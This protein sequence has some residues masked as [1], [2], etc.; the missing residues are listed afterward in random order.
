M[1]EKKEPV[2]AFGEASANEGWMLMPY[3]GI[4]TCWIQL[5]IQQ[6]SKPA[7][8]G[9][10]VTL[11]LGPLGSDGAVVRHSSIKL[12]GKLSTELGLSWL[13]HSVPLGEMAAK[14][15]LGLVACHFKVWSESWIGRRWIGQ[16]SPVAVPSPRQVLQ[17]GHFSFGVQVRRGMEAEGAGSSGMPVLDMSQG[18][19]SPHAVK[20]GC[21]IASL[22]AQLVESVIPQ[23]GSAHCSLSYAND[24][25]KAVLEAI[26]SSQYSVAIAL[27]QELRAAAGKRQ[28][29][30]ADTN[31]SRKTALR[32]CVDN[33]KKDR[34]R[35]LALEGS[36][37]TALLGSQKPYWWVFHVKTV[38]HCSGWICG[39]VQI[40]IPH[41]RQN[42]KSLKLRPF[43]QLG[44]SLQ[45]SW[46]DCRWTNPEEHAGRLEK[47]GDGS[48]RMMVEDGAGTELKLRFIEAGEAIALGSGSFQNP[49]GV[50]MLA[51][52]G[53]VAG[54]SA[55]GI[56]D[57]VTCTRL[58]VE[59]TACGPR[60]TA[61]L[62]LDLGA[63]ARTLARDG[64]SPF[65]AAI[66]YGDPCN[67][68][69]GL[70]EELRQRLSRR[71]PDAWDELLKLPL[72]KG[73]MDV[74]AFALSRGVPIPAGAARDLLDHCFKADLPA[75]AAEVLNELDCRDY[76][77][78][79]LERVD[80]NRAWLSCA[81]KILEQGLRGP[82]PQ[83]LEAETLSYAVEQISRGRSQ[84]RRILQFVPGYIKNSAA[85]YPLTCVLPSRKGGADC[86]ICFEPLSEARPVAF[87]NA[88]GCAV[89]PHFVCQSCSHGLAR[90]EQNQIKCPECRREAK[91][92]GTV[93]PLETDPSF[94]YEFL[95]ARLTA[96]MPRAMLVRALSAMISVDP[97][98]LQ[99]ALDAGAICKPVEQEISLPEF[100][101]NGLYTWALQH[102]HEHAL[103]AQLGRPPDLAKRE[104]WFRYW[105]VKKNGKLTR[106]E[107][108]R[109]ILCSFKV[110]SLEKDRLAMYEI[111]LDKLW[112]AWCSLQT[113]RFGRC[114]PNMITCKEFT[115]SGFSDLLD[116][117]FGHKLVSM[118]EVAE[119]CLGQRPH[120]L[121]S[122]GPVCVGLDLVAPSPFGCA[123]LSSSH[124]AESL[125]AQTTA[126]LDSLG[127]FDGFRDQGETVMSDH[128]A[129]LGTTQTRDVLSCWDGS[130]LA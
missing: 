54:K 75:V 82:K 27:L 63:D 67:L 31:S 76:L 98:A 129:R 97:Q 38:S 95:A 57:P 11:R 101:T 62:L 26:S 127:S 120:H 12:S 110:G 36:V 59:K 24:L 103:C 87:I 47:S 123:T 51:A 93:P 81:D 94:W 114:D 85:S 84:F 2:N 71:D 15:P 21:K 90:L 14:S 35:L 78:P 118:D 112:D 105:N 122:S 34:P 40:G 79:V 91:S 50:Q 65:T 46:E 10:F 7:E 119:P 100:L 124:S 73:H 88:S 43:T 13:L 29:V 70:P 102:L 4:E 66:I 17:A 106:G 1:A 53:V 130:Q 116:Q 99:L 56:F 68:L 77:M 49:L 117:E 30:L 20:S 41:P 80:Y 23:K 108:T 111:K 125:S 89:C 16:T 92:I 39:N 52:D 72:G 74:D 96:P 18:L 61:E 28:E 60:A 109:G 126:A 121:D 64:L 5:W 55:T 33:L 69:H 6:N 45:V 3:V 86:P 37:L 9:F 104:E 58:A 25:G 42:T 19:P 128:S 32:L 107:I 83:W 48:Y 22:P 113:S 44:S 8:G 115:S